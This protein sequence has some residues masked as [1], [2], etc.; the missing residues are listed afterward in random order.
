MPDRKAL[1][2]LADGT[3]YEG[4]LLRLRGGVLWRGRLQYRHDRVPGSAHGSILQG[5]DRHDDV[6]GDRQHGDQPGGHRIE[7]ALGRGVHRPR[8]MGPSVEL[9]ARGVPRRLPSAVSRLR[10]RGNRHPRPHA[11]SSGRRIPDGGPVGDRPRRGSPRGQSPGAPFPDRTRSGEGGHLRPRGPLDHGGLGPREGV[12]SGSGVPG[13]VRTRPA[14]RRHRLRDQ[15]EHP[16]DDG[17]PRVRRD[18][19]AGRH[20]RGGGA[21][22]LSGRRL[23][24][25]RAGRPRRRPVRRR[26]GPRAPRNTSRCSVSASV[27]RSWGSRWGERRSS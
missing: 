23:P 14:D 13:Q 20:N 11:A 6:S 10:D 1:L 8:G 24:V 3:A 9:A 22:A 7:P 16:P 21:G 26:D 18:R 27:I 4:S 25:E 5:T 17:H 19:R 15:A 12:P 2:V